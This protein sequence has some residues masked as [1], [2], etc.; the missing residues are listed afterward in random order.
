MIRINANK[1]LN[2]TARKAAEC[3]TASRAHN[4]TKPKKD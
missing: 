2:A 3:L 4:T 1:A